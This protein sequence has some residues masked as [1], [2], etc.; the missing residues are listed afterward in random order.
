MCLW[1]VSGMAA[2]PFAYFNG[3]NYYQWV[4]SQ[5][6]E[7]P[8][9]DIVKIQYKNTGK[10]EKYYIIYFENYMKLGIKYTFIA[11]M[12]YNNSKENLLMKV[13]RDTKL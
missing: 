11:M 4:T 3:I 13:E 1:L 10:Q 9:E 2:A 6:R 8:A 7:K 5:V 12:K